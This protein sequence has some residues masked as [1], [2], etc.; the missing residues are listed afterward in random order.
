MRQLLSFTMIALLLSLNTIQAQADMVYEVTGTFGDDL[1]GTTTGLA[2]GSFTATYETAGLPLAPGGIITLKSYNVSTFDS[3][4]NLT[5]TYGDRTGVF[6]TIQDA[7]ST[8]VDAS[9]FDPDF[10]SSA[11]LVLIFSSGFD[12]TGAVMTPSNSFLTSFYIDPNNNQ[13]A[14]ASGY[15]SP[16]RAVAEPSSL[17]M[18]GIGGLMMMGFSAYRRRAKVTAG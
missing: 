4:G 2:G 11:S 16:L 7:L 8:E 10:N 6:G 17:I 9:F 1:F 5:Y 18:A 3:L 13:V 12:G 15:S 14:L